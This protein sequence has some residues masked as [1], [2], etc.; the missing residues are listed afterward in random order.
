MRK[1]SKD[2]RDLQQKSHG[3]PSLPQGLY[4]SLPGIPTAQGYQ[5]IGAVGVPIGD[6]TGETIG[7]T[8]EEPLQ[9][10]GSLP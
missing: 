4:H 10:N 2:S 5:V 3:L 7:A 9:R 8:F 6:P 1:N